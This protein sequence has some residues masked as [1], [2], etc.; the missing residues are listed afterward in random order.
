M[1]EMNLIVHT[2]HITLLI[3][4]SFFLRTLRMY[5]NPTVIMTPHICI[6]ILVPVQLTVN[7]TVVCLHHSLHYIDYIIN[8][9]VN[10]LI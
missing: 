1:N 6:T 4:M 9:D 3:P 8:K 5:E 2:L 7:N 10:I